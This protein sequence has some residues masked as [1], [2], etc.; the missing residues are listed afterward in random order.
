M[1]ALSVDTE[2]FVNLAA[3]KVQVKFSFAL[4]ALIGRE[5]FVVHMAEAEAN[6]HS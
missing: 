3:L 2:A 4:T 6:W 5:R 1:L